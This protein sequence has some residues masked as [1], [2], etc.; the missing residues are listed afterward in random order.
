LNQKE[1]FNNNEGTVD[2]DKSLDIAESI[3]QNPENTNLAS[4]P[5]F[6]QRINQEDGAKIIQS[7]QPEIKDNY[8]EN[9]I[10][11]VKQTDKNI[12]EQ[13]ALEIKDTVQVNT[14]K[15]NNSK[16][17]AK[18]GMIVLFLIFSFLL[19]YYTQGFFPF[20]NYYLNATAS[21]SPPDTKILLTKVAA[22]LNSITVSIEIENKGADTLYFPYTK[23]GDSRSVKILAK[24]F[25]SKYLGGI[26]SDTK[27]N[28]A[29][30][31]PEQNFEGIITV[32]PQEKRKYDLV[33]DR[34][35]VATYRDFIII[36]EDNLLNQVFLQ[37][38]QIVL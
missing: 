8:I 20:T 37:F 29:Y 36:S 19:S 21:V 24:T 16:E 10:S 28:V 15:K 2:T 33:F 7:V 17:D 26:F 38:E 34:F 35:P 23:Y 13:P 6:E 32:A 27:L 5:V 4:F 9:H 1:V 3:F 18:Y 14:K 12:I 31:K 30:L 22:G 11:E 25:K